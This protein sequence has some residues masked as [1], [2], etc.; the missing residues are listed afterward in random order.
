[1]GQLV[2][3]HF[4]VGVLALSQRH[5]VNLDQEQKR[6]TNNVNKVI[7][8]ENDK[9]KDTH[10]YT[11]ALFYTMIRKDTYHDDTSM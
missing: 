7:H 11:L 10:K 1:M 8:H 4:R 2:D 9:H 3:G 6:F 5:L